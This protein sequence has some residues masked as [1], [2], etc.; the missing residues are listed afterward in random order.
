VGNSKG[1]LLVENSD[2][3]ALLLQLAL[4]ASGTRVPLA[5]MRSGTEAIQYLHGDGDYANRTEHPLPKLVILEVKL[6]E[7][8]GYEVLKWIREQKELRELPVV[9]LTGFA[10]AEAVRR[11]YELG[12]DSVVKKHTDFA[13]TVE[14]SKAL[15]RYWRK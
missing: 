6:P 10:N 15:G 13:A 4:E 3:D 7:M 8:D 14:M 1:I 11:A 5:R 12:A 9:V 2:D